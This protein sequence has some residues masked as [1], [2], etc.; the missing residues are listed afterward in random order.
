MTTV[1][2]VAPIL[3][4]HGHLILSPTIDSDST[5]APDVA[6]RLT[7]AFAR[8]PGHGLLQLGA[9][10]VQTSMPAVFSY[11]REFASRYV[12]A[13]R[14]FPTL[15]ASIPVPPEA[16]L[17]PLVLAAPVTTGAEYLSASVLA[18]LWSEIDT[19]FHRELSQSKL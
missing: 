5:L 14:T 1:G 9:G 12:V 16:E 3:T 7:E 17:Q 4:P 11:W 13:V 8:G 6:Q 15:P 2:L 18:A 19:A 10:E